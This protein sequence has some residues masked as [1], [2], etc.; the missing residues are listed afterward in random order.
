MAQNMKGPSQTPN[1]STQAASL[2]TD[3]QKANGS[4]QQHPLQ[5]QLEEMH[6]QIEALKSSFQKIPLILLGW[7]LVFVLV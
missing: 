2:A 7:N 3:G 6:K 4:S 5:K 1:T